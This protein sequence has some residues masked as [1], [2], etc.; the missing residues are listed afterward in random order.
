[1][2]K[3]TP[4]PSDEQ[5]RLAALEAQGILDSEPEPEFDALVRMAA[6]LCGAPIALVSLVDDRRQWFKARVGLVVAETPRDLAFCA[7]ALVDDG[8]LEVEDAT[9]DPRF[10]GNPLVLGDPKIRFYAGSPLRTD[11]GHALGTLCVIDRVPR[12]LSLAQREGLAS[13]GRQVMTQMALRRTIHHLHKP[14]DPHLA[15]VRRPEGSPEFSMTVMQS[16]AEPLRFDRFLALGAI[17]EGAMATVYAAYDEELQRRVAVKLVHAIEPEEQARVRREFLALA[18]I[19]HPN[20]VQIYEVGNLGAQTF[21]AMEFVPGVTLTLWQQARHR[22]LRELLAMY[23]QAGRGLVAAHAAGIVH[24]DFKPDNVLVGVDGRP[25]VAD[26][27]LA[28]LRGSDD[29][30]VTTM[31]D[32]RRINDTIVGEVVG[33]PAYMPPEQY[34]G[35]QVDARADQ[36]SFC[37]ALF[38]ALYGARPFAGTT[39]E[40]LRRNLTAGNRHEPAPELRAP[41]ALH[42]AILRGLAPDPMQRWPMLGDLLDHLERYDPDRDA[43]SARRERRSFGALLQVL[44][45][46]AGAMILAGSTKPGFYDPISLLVPGGVV[47]VI[48]GFVL[49]RLRARLLTNHVHRLAIDMMLATGLAIFGGRLLGVIAGLSSD[50]DIML[51]M[52][53]AGA[54]TAAF[55]AFVARFMAWIAV[56]QLVGAVL[57]AVAV[58]PLGVVDVAVQTLSSLLFVRAWNHRAAVPYLS[59]AANSQPLPSTSVT[60]M[61]RDTAR[62]VSES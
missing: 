46:A 23:V 8:I 21:I 41:Q 30:L 13:L 4:H 56:V 50:L 17:G 42:D 62:S 10:S 32:T 31:S 25:R 43:G 38:E 59:L 47:L 16:P 35:S 33:T 29:L 5:G 7:H 54:V 40:E 36:Y 28:R 57:L 12:R 45:L 6:E 9:E 22:S 53:A 20:V 44:M 18:R 37:A 60:A 58:G 49:W 3:G 26:F 61:P 15:T 11:D 14:A 52:L 55:A 48:L 24:R 39:I 51:G 19:S 1:M 27:G 34:A 2:S